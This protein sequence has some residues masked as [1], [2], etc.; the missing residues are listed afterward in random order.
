V[1]LDANLARNFAVTERWQLQLR[2]EAYN[3]TNTPSFNN[4]NAN[5]STPASFM[6]ITSART[7]SGSLE[8]GERAL[9]F[10]LRLSF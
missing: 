4:P 8:G 10:G 2:A 6:T 7:R 9:R 1:N 3:L 5:A